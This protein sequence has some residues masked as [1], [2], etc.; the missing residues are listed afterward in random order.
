[1]PKTNMDGCGPGHSQ[2]EEEMSEMKGEQLSNDCVEVIETG[3]EVALPSCPHKDRGVDGPMA[4]ESRSIDSL[5]MRK[6]DRE[7]ISVTT[8]RGSRA[9]SL[10]SV[11]GE[12]IL[13]IFLIEASLWASFFLCPPLEFP[14][15]LF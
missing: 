12:T 8:Q 3:E 1:M 4:A 11:S 9:A 13:Y 6:C 15:P 2:E 5:L 10:G 7:P 14:F